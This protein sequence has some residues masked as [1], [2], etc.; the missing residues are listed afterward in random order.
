VHAASIAP[1]SRRLHDREM[2]PVLPRALA[3][4]RENSGVDHSFS[5]RRCLNTTPVLLKHNTQRRGEP[6]LL[7]NLGLAAV[8]SLNLSIFSERNQVLSILP[9]TNS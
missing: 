2:P 3:L 8:W 1:E 7:R 5:D 6:A 9:L 4:P